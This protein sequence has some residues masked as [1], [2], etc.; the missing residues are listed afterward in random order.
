MAY[1]FVRKMSLYRTYLRSF[2]AAIVPVHDILSTLCAKAVN[3]I[4]EQLYGVLI[5]DPSMQV[6]FNQVRD[7]GRPYSQCTVGGMTI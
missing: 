3:P 4:G 1:L 6:F 7:I 5:E 2:L